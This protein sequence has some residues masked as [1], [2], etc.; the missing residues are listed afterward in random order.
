V[1][2]EGRDLAIKASVGAAVVGPGERLSVD[3]LL[4]RADVAMY[5]AKAQGK[6]R[7]ATWAPT[8]DVS[9]G[10]DPGG[11]RHARAAR[12]ATGAPAAP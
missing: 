8:M 2:I 3:E 4:R 10:A 7:L 12:V 5:H 6:D 9:P 11:A 1:R